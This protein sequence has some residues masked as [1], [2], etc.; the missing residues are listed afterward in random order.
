MS[1]H[2]VFAPSKQA[3][4]HQIS[5]T[6]RWEEGYGGKSLKWKSL[7]VFGDMYTMNSKNI[8]CWIRI[9]NTKMSWPKILLLFRSRIGISGQKPVSLI[10][11]FNPKCQHGEAHSRLDGIVELSPNE[12]RPLFM[13]LWI[14]WPLPK[15][16][17][18]ALTAIICTEE[19]YLRK[20]YF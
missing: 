19:T 11:V 1:A 13:L 15:K 10:S 3:V 9:L 8:C 7:S 2:K 16:N 12:R 6:Y 18:F 5:W 20:V 4:A 17:R 14:E